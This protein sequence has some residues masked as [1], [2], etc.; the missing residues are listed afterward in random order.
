MPGSKHASR[1]AR[2]QAASWLTGGTIKWTA[3]PCAGK[4]FRVEHVHAVDDDVR[5][6]RRV[7]MRAFVGRVVLDRRRVEHHEIGEEALSDLAA[8]AQ[9]HLCSGSAGHP[10][11][12][13]MQTE[14]LVFA[15]VLAEHARKGSVGTWMR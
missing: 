11:H 9:A 4:A 7:L 12:R 8:I 14:D 1:R 2:Y 6:P 15:H 5:N 10:V 13:I 3:G